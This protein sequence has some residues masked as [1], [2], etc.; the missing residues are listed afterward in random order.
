MVS[1]GQRETQGELQDFCVQCHTPI[2]KLRGETNVQYDA[3]NDVHVQPTKGLSEDVMD[4]VSCQVCHSITKVNGPANANFEFVLDGVRRAPIQDPDPTPA[5]DSVYS[6]THKNSKFCGTCHV[7]VNQKN[8]PLEATYSEWVASTFNG[9]KSCQD[10]HMPSAQAPAAVD[11]RERTVHDHTFVG[12]D[13]SLLPPDD[14]PGYDELRSKTEALLQQSARFEA[15][16]VPAERRLD[17]TLEN[18]AGHALPSGATADREMWIELLVT[19]DGGNVVLESGTLDERG[20]LRTAN[21]DHTT[22]PG[23]DE[24]LVLYTQ[25]MTFDPRLE[26]PASVEPTSPVDFLWEPNGLTDHLI[27]PGVTDHPSYDLGAL[28][29][30]HYSAALRLLFRS[31]PPHLLRKLETSG[32][33]D[34]AVKERVP[35]VEMATF[36]LDFTLP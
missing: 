1:V 12:A 20:D 3:A 28:P 11:H 5:H 7:V 2:G 26:D 14:F 30:G 36:V 21:A 23:S 24:A 8:A 10:C 15:V 27:G 35:T 34:A 16:A 29:A 19:D 18:L 32:G 25:V 6:D 4:G 17:V 31:F 9:A 33:L 22:R 13:V